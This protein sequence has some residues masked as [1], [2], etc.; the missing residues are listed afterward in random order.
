MRTS[1]GRLCAVLAGATALVLLGSVGGAVAGSLLTGADIKDQSIRAR[2]IAAG[3]VASSELRDGSVLGFD[4]AAGTVSGRQLLNG[5]VGLPDL[6]A[7]VHGELA[8]RAQDGTDGV[9]RLESD[10][11]RPGM[12]QLKDFPG[13]GENSTGVWTA[14]RVADFHTSWVTCPD[15]KAA[16]GGGFS[17]DT[18]NATAL[19]GLQVVTSAPAQI[20]TSTADDPLTPTDER[21][22]SMNGGYTPVE[23]D[24][25]GSFVPNGWVVEGFNNGNTD[26]VVRPW[27]VCAAVG[28]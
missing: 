12:T 13:N 3:G 8:E 21:V 1:L 10:G 25:A 20:N 28:D 14:G 11:A 17:R 24:A 27:V 16:L 23:G 9:A 26:L 19:K 4:V 15:G 22:V 7:A 18:A 6:S 5:T 2:D